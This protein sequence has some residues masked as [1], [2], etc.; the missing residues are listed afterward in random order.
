MAGTFL[1][2]RTGDIREVLADKCTKSP[3]EFWAPEPI[4]PQVKTPLEIRDCRGFDLASAAD[5][6]DTLGP[7]TRAG[8]L[9]R[10]WALPL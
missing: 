5:R 1:K 4:K 7:A 3:A 6:A 2:N 9:N 10:I 8:P